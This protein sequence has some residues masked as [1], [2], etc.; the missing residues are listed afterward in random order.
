MEYASEETLLG[1]LLFAGSDLLEAARGIVSARDFGGLSHQCLWHA[2]NWSIDVADKIDIVVVRDR[3]T[4]I[5]PRIWGDTES[6]YQM[7][8]FMAEA[9]PAPTLARVT[10]AAQKV[11]REAIA[12]DR[13]QETDIFESI[14]R[15]LTLR[16]WRSYRDLCAALLSEGFEKICID[17]GLKSLMS[18][19]II[20]NRIEE[21]QSLWQ[22]TEVTP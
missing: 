12:R 17:A 15:M 5:N 21:K 13:F 19:D 18:K 3:L 1:L 2:I 4:E 20:Q 10:I 14:V 11:R 9:A 16:G 8:V 22:L 6:T 7:L